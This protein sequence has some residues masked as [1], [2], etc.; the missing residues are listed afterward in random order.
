MWLARV[1][2][3]PGEAADPF[4]GVEDDRAVPAVVAFGPGE[5]DLSVGGGRDTVHGHRR[6]DHVPGD[7]GQTCRLFVEDQVAPVARGMRCT[8]YQCL[9]E[10]PD[11][12]AYEGGPP[13]EEG[14]RG[15]G[16]GR[17]PR[18]PAVCE[19]GDKIEPDPGE[20]MV[21]ALVHELREDGLSLRQIDEELRVRGHRPRGGRQWHVQTILKSLRAGR[22]LRG[23]DGASGSALAR[24]HPASIDA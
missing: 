2:D 5:E 7:V 17:A 20:Q 9:R 3:V 15:A 8:A 10:G 19:D 18:L 6:A 22:G 24:G 12:R 13:R 11:R 21:I 16:R 23:V 1:R 4:E 14:A